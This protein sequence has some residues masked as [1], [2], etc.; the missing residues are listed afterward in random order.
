[1]EH[2]ALEEI[3]FIITELKQDRSVPKNV[4]AKLENMERIFEDNEEDIYIKVDRALQMVEE[5]MEDANL[6][7]FVRTKLWNICSL[8]ESI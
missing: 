5:I 4:V 2:E 3:H 1:M 7:P 6:Q 8:L